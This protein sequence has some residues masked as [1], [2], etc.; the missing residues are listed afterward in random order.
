[1]IAKNKN[2]VYNMFSGRHLPTVDLSP[3]EEV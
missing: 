3:F 2:S 1:M